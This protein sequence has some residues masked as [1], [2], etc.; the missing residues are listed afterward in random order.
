M[1]FRQRTSR[2]CEEKK[3]KRT[4]SFVRVGG[5]HPQRI[6][7]CLVAA[8]VAV[9]KETAG[10]VREPI[11][12]M[13]IGSNCRHDCPVANGGSRSIRSTF[14]FS[15]SIK[16]STA[17]SH[18]KPPTSCDG[19]LWWPSFLFNHDSAFRVEVQVMY[20]STTTTLSARGSSLWKVQARQ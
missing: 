9:K 6:R 13:L 8:P 4:P 7:R 17:S 5:S 19:F 2:G 3:W 14:A 20:P 10:R 12:E 11:S 18:F 15:A 16:N 1:R